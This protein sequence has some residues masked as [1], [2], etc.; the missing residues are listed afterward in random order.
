MNSGLTIWGYPL[1]PPAWLLFNNFWQVISFRI[2]PKLCPVAVKVW[3]SPGGY[4]E[5]NS[6]LSHL[7]PFFQHGSPHRVNQ[8][9]LTNQSFFT[10]KSSDSEQITSTGHEELSGAWETLI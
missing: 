2:V 1:H 4:C 3:P 10:L 9:T 8:Q 5:A 6:S 7:T